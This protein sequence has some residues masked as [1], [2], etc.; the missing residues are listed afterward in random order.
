[1]LLALLF[2]LCLP[3]YASTWL[4][5]QTP[6][7]TV[8]IE[9]SPAEIKLT[10]AQTRFTVKLEACAHGAIEQ[11]KKNWK[12]ASQSSPEVVQKNALSIQLASEHRQVSQGSALGRLV[13]SS[14]MEFGL[15]KN[16]VEIA[17][18]K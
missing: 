8:S 14:A 5:S 13:S 4:Y 1:M 6:A 10:S 18:A 15:L 12:A 7:G 3:T 2:I 11:F 17:C 16:Q 9:E